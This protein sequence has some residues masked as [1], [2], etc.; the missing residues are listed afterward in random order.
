[1]EKPVAGETKCLGW[2]NK[3]FMS[4]DKKKI[5]FCISC[6]R[7]RDNISYNMSRAETQMLGREE[8]VMCEEENI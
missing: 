4:P 6:R 7:K 8:K 2:C 5:R 3:T 1:M